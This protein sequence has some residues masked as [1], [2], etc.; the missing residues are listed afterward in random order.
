M[1]LFSATC[2]KNCTVTAVFFH[3]LLEFFSFLLFP[4]KKE[5]VDYVR[6]LL[7]VTCLYCSRWWACWWNGKLGGWGEKSGSEGGKV[8]DQG[9]TPHFVRKRRETA[10]FFTSFA[11][12]RTAL[13]WILLW[14]T[15]GGVE[16]KIESCEVILLKCALI[17]LSYQLINLH[18]L[19]SVP[20][21]PTLY[22]CKTRRESP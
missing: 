20:V 9:R 17:E 18:S 16:G 4:Q 6:L 15:A 19:N 5:T 2:S 12:L 1:H 3:F 14:W 22:Y 21:L 7:F 10:V 8:T 11:L 13:F